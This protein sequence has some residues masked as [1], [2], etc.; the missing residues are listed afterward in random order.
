[1]ILND[2]LDRTRFNMLPG[3]GNKALDRTC[4]CYGKKPVVLCEEVEFVECD[5]NDPARSPEDDSD[6]G[7][8]T[9]RKKPRTSVGI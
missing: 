3:G 9:S 1:M 7:P 4:R 6:Y 8:V 2:S 5:H